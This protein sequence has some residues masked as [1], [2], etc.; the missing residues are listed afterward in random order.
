LD[1]RLRLPLNS[2]LAGSVARG[3]AFGSDVL[4]FYSSGSDEKRKELEARGI[5]VEQLPASAP[6][7]RPDLHAV[8][9]RLG[10]LEITSVM[11]EA[12]AQVNGAALAAGVVDKVFLYYSPQIMGQSAAIPFASGCAPGQAQEPQ[13]LSNLSVHRFGEDVAVEGYLREP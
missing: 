10:E 11:I 9:R 6:G 7:G 2:R 1:S 13:T 12:G 8:L 4:V 5:Q 3:T